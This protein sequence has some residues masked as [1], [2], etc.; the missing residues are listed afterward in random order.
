MSF[1]RMK[2][3][4]LPELM[5]RL[6]GMGRGIAITPLLEEGIHFGSGKVL[7]VTGWTITYETTRGSFAV[8]G[9]TI[10]KLSMRRSQSGRRVTDA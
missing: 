6:A 9:K 3:G 7:Y 5:D 4:R 10:P 2:L 1:G 8:S